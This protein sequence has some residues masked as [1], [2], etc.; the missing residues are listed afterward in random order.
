MRARYDGLADWYEER[1][2]EGSEP[3]QPG[4]LELLG[5]GSGPCLDIGCGT[6]R[7]FESIRASGRTIVGLDFS[8]DQLGLARTRTDGPLLHGDAAVLPFADE[9]FDTA[10][11]MWI[12]TDV[13]DFGAVLREAA[14]VLRPGGILVAYGVHPCFNGPHVVYEEDGRR[15][16][17]PTYRQAG[18]HH[19]SPWWSDDGIRRRIGM[20]HLPLAEYLNAIIKSGLTAEHFEEPTGPDIPHALAFRARKS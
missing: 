12:S 4:M 18:W 1:F 8:K 9:S 11:T 15:T 14:R 17:Y 5:P 3:H 13:D 2:V 20:R 19:D 10:I 6:G 7:N 16:A